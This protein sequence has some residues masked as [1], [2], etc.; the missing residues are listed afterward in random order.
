MVRHLGD[1]ACFGLAGAVLGGCAVHGGAQAG[2]CQKQAAQHRRWSV[3]K[4]CGHAKE[5]WCNAV[6]GV[7]C[8]RAAAGLPNGQ[9]NV[10]SWVAVAW[11]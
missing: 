7:W 2:Q 3:G 6:H 10:G 9:V 5:R 11:G 8:V 4:A 1:G